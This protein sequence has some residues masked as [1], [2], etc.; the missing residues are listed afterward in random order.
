MGSFAEGVHPNCMYTIS[1]TLPAGK[2]SGTA[3]SKKEAK[4]LA[5]ID[6]LNKV[7]NVVYPEGVAFVQV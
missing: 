2:F 7:Y 4:K 5:A 1:V 3:K 6:A